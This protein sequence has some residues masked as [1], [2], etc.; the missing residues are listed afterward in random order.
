MNRLIDVLQTA[1]YLFQ[2][3]DIFFQI[4]NLVIKLCGLFINLAKGIADFRAAS[5]NH[6]D[7]A[8][9]INNLLAV[10]LI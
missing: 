5:G 2:I 9:N 3:G 8:V 4:G 10:F 1:V 6:I 7:F